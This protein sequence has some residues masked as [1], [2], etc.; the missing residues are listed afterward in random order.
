MGDI[1][2]HRKPSLG[3]MVINQCLAN[4]QDGRCR[5]GSAFPTTPTK[6][7]EIE[8]QEHLRRE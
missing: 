8:E 3:G 5:I 7:A 4:P 6:E 2:R 1:Q